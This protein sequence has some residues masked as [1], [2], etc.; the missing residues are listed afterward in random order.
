MDFVSD[1]FRIPL[2]SLGTDVQIDDPTFN[3]LLEIEAANIVDGALHQPDAP[4][5]AGPFWLARFESV[6][7]KLSVLAYSTAR[8]ALT[9]W[10]TDAVRDRARAEG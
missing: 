7:S 9:N 2:L 3:T 1:G 8:D 6:K 5:S 4:S 10:T